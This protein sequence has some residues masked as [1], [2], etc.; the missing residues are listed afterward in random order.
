[1]EAVRLG[2]PCMDALRAANAN[3]A[4]RMSVENKLY[5]ATAKEAKA[6]QVVLL[7]ERN[8]NVEIQEEGNVVIEEV[9]LAEATLAAAKA[10]VLRIEAEIKLAR[11]NLSLAA[12]SNEIETCLRVLEDCEMRYKDAVVNQ[13]NA[14]ADCH[15]FYKY[16]WNVSRNSLQQK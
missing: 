14:T 1:M 3:T 5:I 7:A 13:S 8:L 15:S 9:R 6:A 4:K 12:C 10:E 16:L 11:T 2:Y